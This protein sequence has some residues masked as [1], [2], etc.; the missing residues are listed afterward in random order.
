MTGN[1]SVLIPFPITTIKYYHHFKIA[2]REYATKGK[3]NNFPRPDTCPFCGTAS[4]CLIGWGYYW[5]WVTTPD[6]CYRIPI[7]LWKCR[8]QETGGYISIQ[9]TFLVPRKQCSFNVLYLLL[10]CI[11]LRGADFTTGLE[12]VIKHGERLSYQAVRQWVASL[13]SSCGR[14]IGILQGELEAPVKRPAKSF[15]DPELAYLAAVLTRFLKPARTPVQRDRLHCLLL[16]RYR[17]SPLTALPA[18]DLI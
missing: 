7:K 5:R 12:T 1:L 6:G 13:K 4:T 11:F 18:V 10:R 8:R 9:P 3:E 2:A 14:W 17:G 15:R 16:N